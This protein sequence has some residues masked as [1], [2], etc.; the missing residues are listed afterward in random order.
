[1]AT[2]TATKQ[3]AAS[4]AKGSG[5]AIA[6]AKSTAVAVYDAELAAELT[7][8]SG[9]GFEEAT[10]DAFAIPFL[11]ILQD[12][13]PQVKKSK[14]EYIEGAK[15]GQIYQNVNQAVSDA[16][17]VIPCH[18]SQVFI[19]WVPRNKGG[20]FV[21]A[22]DPESGAAKMRTAVRDGGKS[23]LPNGNELYDTRQHF[24]LEILEDGSTRPAL[25]AM[26]S[27]GLKISRRWM[28]QMQTAT[29]EVAGRKIQ[30][31]MFAWSYAL[32]T[33]EESN[34]QGAWY[35]WVIGEKERVTDIELYRLAKSFGASM[36][37]GKVKVNYEEMQAADT[38][39]GGQGHGETPKDIN[40][41]IDA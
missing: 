35:Q 22:Y 12:L 37:Q 7:G 24:V 39:A 36:A 33:E 16:V 10:R 4:P 18:F 25:I 9:R 41:E 6:A 19:E 15:A 29:I 20:G 26:K 23:T 3:V 28:S 34:D 17:R 31:P 21:A 13:S 8:D 2:K 14:S 27:S 32:S 11:A 40:N 38:A 5:K 1:V 30:P